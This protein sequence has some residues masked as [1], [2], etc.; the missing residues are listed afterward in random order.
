MA[1][2]MT[3]ERISREDGYLYYLGKDEQERKKV[4]FWG[5]FCPLFFYHSYLIQRER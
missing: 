2:R 5:A 1:E 4:N 3:R